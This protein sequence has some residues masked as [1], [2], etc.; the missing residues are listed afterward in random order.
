VPL[1]PSPK[2]TLTAVPPLKEV[3]VKVLPPM[4]PVPEVRAAVKADA[5]PV[6]P[7]RPRTDSALPVPVTDR[8]ALTP[9]EILSWPEAL[10]DEAVWPDAVASVPPP[11]PLSVKVCTPVAKS[12]AFSV[13]AIVALC[14]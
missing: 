10:I 5:V 6:L 12:I 11:L 4:P 7:A 2:V 14:R 13:S 1:V 9:V 8:S 3:K